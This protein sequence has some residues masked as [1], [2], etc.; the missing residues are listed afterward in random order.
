M[1]YNCKT[2]KCWRSSVGKQ[3]ISHRTTKNHGVLPKPKAAF[4]H[5]CINFLKKR[6][7]LFEMCEQINK[8]QFCNKR[9]TGHTLRSRQLVH[10]HL[11]VFPMKY[12]T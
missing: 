3:S 11:V 1:P 7:S 12:D 9:A 10:Y 8:L 2:V 5:D 6:W 4:T